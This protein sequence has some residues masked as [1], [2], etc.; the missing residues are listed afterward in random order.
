MKKASLVIAFCFSLTTFG[1]SMGF[2]LKLTGGAAYITS[3]GYNDGIEGTNALNAAD[4]ASVTGSFSKLQLGMNFGGE[5]ILDIN[6]NFGIGLGAGYMQFSHNTETV[7]GNWSMFGIPFVDTITLKPSVTSIP[8]TLNVHYTMPMGGL[9]LNLFAGVG[10][11]IS[12]MKVDQS[13]NSTSGTFTAASSYTFDSNSISGQIGFQGGLGL[14]IPLGGDFSF[15]VDITG[16]Y[17]SLGDIKGDYTW[18]ASL[19]GF[20]LVDQTGTDSFFYTYEFNNSGTWNRLLDWVTD[21]AKP[22]GAHDR[23]AV[24]GKFD[25]TGVSAQ[26]GFKVGF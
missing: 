7:T 20:P 8:I 21:A 5:I 2:S 4:Y 23:N 11:Y 18:Q 26:A 3:G 17:V 13:F 16:R 14:E 12:K 15:I 22:S 25:L 9:N 10:Y 19:M 6:E 1:F 24:H